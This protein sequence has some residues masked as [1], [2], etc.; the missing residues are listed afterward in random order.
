MQLA[1]ARIVL[2]R[3]GSSVQKNNITPAQ[4]QVLQEIHQSNV[5][6]CPVVDLKIIG[7][8]KATVVTGVDSEGNAVE[9][10]VDRT[11]RMEVRRLVQEY[12]VKRV[13]MMFPGKN[14]VL[15]KTF[16]EAE[17]QEGASYQA[18][19]KPPQEHRI[20]N[21]PADPNA[22]SASAYVESFEDG[23]VVA[24]KAE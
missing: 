8:A 2:D 19:A 9:K 17:F 21:F 13:A 10:V 15:P 3:F 20:T 5:G 24:S 11:D 14:P 16:E 18:P 22:P 12:G 6:T 4:A 1:N 23:C 7:D